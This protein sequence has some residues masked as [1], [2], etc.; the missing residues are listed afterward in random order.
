MQNQGKLSKK[1]IKYILAGLMVSLMTMVTGACLIATIESNQAID[2]ESIP[3]CIVATQFIGA[4]VGCCIVYLK[5]SK[6]LHSAMH[7][8]LLLVLLLIINCVFIRTDNLSWLKTAIVI[9][10]GII[11][12][13]ALLN[14]KQ[15]R[16]FKYTG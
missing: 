5:T 7:L 9:L 3:M 2:A 10:S 14:K 15:K 6:I 13:A 11:P 12:S 4:A 16:R 8:S 1:Q